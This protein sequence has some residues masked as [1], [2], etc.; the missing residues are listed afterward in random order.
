MTDKYIVLDLEATCDEGREDD[1]MGEIIEIGACLASVDGKI[2]SEFQTYIRPVDRPVL[3][4]FCTKLTH[5]TQQQ[6]DQAPEYLAAI[7]AFDRWVIDCRRNHGP[8]VKW[9]SWGEYDRK[10]FQRN[11]VR[12]NVRTPLI[13][14]YEHMN[15]KNVYGHAVG[16]KKKMVGL[17]KALHCEKMQ[18]QGAQHCGLDD[19][20]NAA[21]L[22]PIA[23]GLVKSKWVPGKEDYPSMR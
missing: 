15:L 11:S 10:A 21:R 7:E 8:F 13:L 22:L 17:G 3:T 18:F 9:G 23:F 2:I 1:Q 12:L 16:R 6:V 14:A 5:I 4:E 19:A 20:K